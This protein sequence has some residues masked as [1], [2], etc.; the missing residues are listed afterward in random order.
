MKKVL[1]LGDSIRMGYDDYVKEMLE[2]KCEVYYDAA[3][4]G[5]F[6]AYTLWQ[7]NQLFRKY[8]PFD[9]VHWNNGYWD[10]NVEAPMQTALYPIEDYKYLLRRIA[11]EIKKNGA[12]VIFALTTPVLDAGAAADNSGTGA[13]YISYD[14]NWVRKYNAAACEVMKEENIPINDLYTLCRQDKNYYKCEDMLHLTEEGYRAC[15]E[16]S[17]KLI[18]EELEK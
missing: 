8:G 9:I 12:K 17:S 3:D 6:A 2:G 16:Q 15:A 14:D 4:N 10:M 1:L 7:M 18:L 11:R 13:E 5:R